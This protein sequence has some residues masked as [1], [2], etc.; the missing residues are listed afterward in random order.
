MMWVTVFSLIF[1]F[2]LIYFL[3]IYTEYPLLCIND[4]NVLQ[5]VPELYS[6]NNWK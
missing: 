6:D 3:D 2:I 4:E 1:K 5:K